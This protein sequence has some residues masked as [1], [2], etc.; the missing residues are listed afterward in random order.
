MK[1]QEKNRRTGFEIAII[2][3]ACRF[4][5]ASNP[6]EYW[7][8]LVEGR[9]CITKLSDESLSREGVS[10][11]ILKDKNYIKSAFVLNNIKQ[12]DADFFD[13][14]PQEASLTDPQQRLLM[15]STWEALEDAGYHPHNYPGKISIYA[16]SG[17]NTYLHSNLIKIV[18][19][20]TDL[21]VY[22]T[23]H[24]DSIAMRI[25]YKL[26]LKGS[27]M[28][29]QTACSTSLAAT[30]LACQ[31][32]LL[33]EAEIAIAAAVKISVPHHVGYSFQEGGILS[34]DGHCRPFDIN[35]SGT[36]MGNGAGVVV[37]K[38]LDQAIED[39]DN[40]YAVIKGSAVNNDGGDKMNYVSPGV[41]GQ[42]DVIRTAIENA[43]IDP[44]TLSYIETHGT[45][46]LLGDAV[47]IASLTQA[48]GEKTSKKQF[49]AIGS[50]K[51]NLGHLDVA[52]GMASLI[53]TSLSLKHKMIP[54]SINFSEPSQKIDFQNSPF[55]VNTVLK[56][57]EPQGFVRRAGISGFG[58]GG[59][60]AH[61]LLE[62][63]D[64]IFETKKTK[65]L[66]ML[67]F[68]AKTKGALHLM[69]R[70]MAVYLS[71]NP[72]VDIADVAYTLG[73]GRSHFSYR[74]I[75]LAKTV[76]EAREKLHHYTTFEIQNI[77]SPSSQWDADYNEIH[78]IASQWE[79]G[80][81][82]CWKTIYR[83]EK[84]RRISL[85]TYPF[86]QTE[87]W[88]EAL[89][90]E[91]NTVSHGAEGKASDRCIPSQDEIT[92]L[93]CEWMKNILGV[94][95]VNPDH[96]FFEMGGDSLSAINLIAKIGEK[97]D[98]SINMSEVFSAP[99]PQMLSE[100]IVKK[101]CGKEQETK[102]FALS[103]SEQR[104]W[105]AEQITTKSSAYCVPVTFRLK[106]QLSIGK[107]Q[108]ALQQIVGRHECFR[109]AFSLE[110]ESPVRFVNASGHIQCRVLDCAVDSEESSYTRALEILTEECRSGFALETAPLA[111]ACLISYAKDAY[112]FGFVMHHIL[113]DAHSMA[114]LMEELGQLYNDAPLVPL[115]P[116]HFDAVA[117]EAQKQFWQT[118]L[119]QVPLGIS[120]VHDFP[121]SN[122]VSIPAKR[123][124]A[125]IPEHTVQAL[126]KIAHQ[127]QS[128][129][130]VVL[131]SAWVTLLY[132][133]TGETDFLVGYPMNQRK[134]RSRER[135][136]GPL[137]NTIPFRAVL[138]EAM[139]FLE[140]VRYVHRQHTLIL[141]NADLSYEE[142]VNEG[143]RDR[144]HTLHP[145]I[146]N[147]F[148]YQNGLEVDLSLHRVKSEVFEIELGQSQHDITLVLTPWNGSLD[149]VLEYNSLL[150]RCDHIQEVLD[151]WV[152]LLDSIQDNCIENIDKIE[153]L[154][155]KKK[156]RL[157][158]TR[159]RPSFKTMID[160]FETQVACSPSA[161]AVRFAESKLTYEKLNA[162]SN[163]L[164]KYLIK[165][166][167]KRGRAVVVQSERSEHIVIA[168]LAIFKAGAVYV[169][170]APCAPPARRDKQIG[171]INPCLILTDA[172]EKFALQ[173]AIPTVSIPSTEID[174]FS[175]ENLHLNVGSDELAYILF[176]SGSAGEPKGVEVSHGALANTLAWRINETH[177][178]S[179]DAVLHS[180]SFAFDPSLWQALGPL[181]SGGCVVIGDDRIHTDLDYFISLID[182][183]K[184]T[185]LDFT[186]SLLRIFL[187]IA[188]PMKLHSVRHVFCGGE[189]FDRDL[190]SPFFQSF[191]ARLFNQYGPTETTIDATF[192]P[193]EKDWNGIRIPIGKPIDNVETHVLDKHQKL[194]P[195]G[196]IGELYIG[197]KGLARGYFDDP[198]QT[199][200][201][202]INLPSGKFYRTGDL[203]RYL[204]SGDIEFIH[205]KDSQVKVSG[206][207]I[208]LQE[209][210][211]VANLHP[212]VEISCARVQFHSLILYVQRK[213]ESPTVDGLMSFFQE[214]LP[215]YMI[216]RQI[217]VVERMPLTESWKVDRKRVAQLS[218]THPTESGKQAMNKTEEML[219][220]IYAEVLQ[221]KV[222]QIH[223]Q[224]HFFSSGGTSLL[225]IQAI[226]RIRRLFN[227]DIPVTELFKYSILSDLA[228]HLEKYEI[229]EEKCD[230]YEN[231]GRIPLSFSQ[232]YLDRSSNAN[233][234]P[235]FLRLQG[236][237]DIARLEKSI[238]FVIGQHEMLR[239]SLR[240][241]DGEL[242][243]EIKQQRIIWLEKND[244]SDLLFC[245]KSSQDKF[246]SFVEKLFDLF[247]EDPFRV[248]LYLFKENTFILLF[249]LHRI[250]Y[251]GVSDQI[252]VRDLFT[253]YQDYSEPSK[254]Q[255][256]DRVRYRDFVEWEKKSMSNDWIGQK[257]TQVA[258]SLKEYSISLN[259]TSKASTG[260]FLV[261]KIVFDLDE[262]CF[263]DQLAN[264]KSVTRFHLF[265]ALVHKALSRCLREGKYVF[266]VPA[267]GR[268]DERFFDVLGRF[269]N[270]SL[271]PLSLDQELSLDACI[272]QHQA[273]IIQ[274]LENQ[275]L[276]IQCLLEK[277]R[278]IT[279]NN[280]GLDGFFSYFEE[281]DM[282]E[283]NV[284][285]SIHRETLWE[286]QPEFPL[287]IQ[288]I[289]S[290][291]QIVMVIKYLKTWE[292]TDISRLRDV[293]WEEKE[294]M[295]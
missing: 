88:I 99:T 42:V 170:M 15:E 49:C 152:V 16:G 34:K 76:E 101:L 32:L 118:Y 172:C 79:K 201:K 284:D 128:T 168:I 120:L 271:V 87:Y 46:T 35:A 29:V 236:N 134:S 121:Q 127:E 142:I 158:E 130:F 173:S 59:T 279:R 100:S 238:H 239:M 53:K 177:L 106:G 84:L 93:I 182:K 210:E 39:R 191:S 263:L 190:I 180:I 113:T 137:I 98:V 27:A 73:V 2:G 144:A 55:Y 217:Q 148:V 70:N 275:T 114:I 156:H 181:C 221:I 257:S 91:N 141:D 129:L 189:S 138:T 196:A 68:A 179:R 23:N 89:P 231:G 176:T 290:R 52:A 272:Q 161:I 43:K 224:S 1:E 200:L 33:G 203:A 40:I 252:L 248:S 92:G 62:E 288:V 139:S 140:V 208:D 228:L 10:D 185:V 9:E 202:F 162:L 159:E 218:L 255:V 265:L 145:L 294:R 20:V 61:I 223:R 26:N 146:Q 235:I 233:N 244:Y 241:C 259:V 25:A 230:S 50:V 247:K 8:N 36:V 215:E 119:D 123:V 276:P 281:I 267:M 17:I 86:H 18:P 266:A 234:V 6:K 167:C 67:P 206:I 41:R 188:D 149:C 125:R 186:P 56:T 78:S 209:I 104:F 72:T 65:E 282:Q 122:R 14:P 12:F 97:F 57:W 4:P 183:H 96:N 273:T 45:A 47:E 38:L 251:D 153:L 229:K 205:R 211:N 227:I 285:F 136:I 54:P 237:V 58:L 83:H 60:N 187:K 226:S 214:R 28:T 112:L 261:D 19:S 204:S 117:G 283:F 213:D 74:K 30:H 71:D 216:P 207:R 278:E 194:C 269:V 250:I 193:V 270:L 291:D 143:L 80:G 175:S 3:M 103:H 77:G 262:V 132:R 115:A 64:G 260:M 150:F 171:Q 195:V 126:S 286:E 22:I 154:S 135:E 69:I 264:Q 108:N 268:P 274:T 242:Y 37:L 254:F 24:I 105:L 111:R 48:I 169:P 292:G 232:Q 116:F 197:G 155:A 165:H 222:S 220:Q 90:E 160:R 94:E 5:H 184:V 198:A 31:S 85:P 199:Q 7:R 95:E 245:Q 212:L 246:K 147:F 178:G 219:A 66:W 249:V 131:L 109:T 293:F 256:L 151:A 280:S 295:L 102:R 253:Y 82:I 225:A 243:Q 174:S 11:D 13:V 44:A 63:F 51:S 164:A 287:S 75:F 163:Q 240:D 289:R 133:Y 166:G 81:D 258:D 110:E 277:Y 124:A 21:N 157:L 192:W 107:L